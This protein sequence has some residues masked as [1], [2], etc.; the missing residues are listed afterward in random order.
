MELFG[1][2]SKESKQGFRGFTQPVQAN[3]GITALTIHC[4][5]ISNALWSDIMKSFSGR[6]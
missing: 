1:E 5:E 6:T 2:L 3:V 4:H